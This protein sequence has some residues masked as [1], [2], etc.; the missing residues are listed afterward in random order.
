M[1]ASPKTNLTYFL[2]FIVSDS[3]VSSKATKPVRTPEP[4]TPE[5]NEILPVQRSAEAKCKPTKPINNE[6]SFCQA[7]EDDALKEGLT[8]L[9]TGRDTSV[10]QRCKTCKHRKTDNQSWAEHNLSEDHIKGL[11]NS[12][13]CNTALTQLD[14]EYRKVHL[15]FVGASTRKGLEVDF[16]NRLHRIEG[17]IQIRKNSTPNDKC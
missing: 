10:G 16:L 6:E 11:I 2:T 12:R 4:T 7:L 15:P 1:V 3:P 8:F 9:L 13:G 14:Q 17:L 5:V